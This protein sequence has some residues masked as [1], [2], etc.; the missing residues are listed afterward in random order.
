M[1]SKLSQGKVVNL[2]VNACLMPIC[3]LDGTAVVTVEGIGNT[4]DGM[5]EVQKRL[6][7]SHGS[8]CGF[9][10][11]GIVMSMYTLLRN[12]SK[13]TMKE[14]EHGLDGNLCRCTGYRP[15]LDAFKNFA[16]DTKTNDNHINNNSNNIENHSSNHTNHT[17]DTNTLDGEPKKKKVRLCGGTG[18]PCDCPEPSTEGEEPTKTRPYPLNAEPIFPP[19]LHNHPIHSLM[20][21]NGQTTWYRPTSLDEILYLKE[22]FPHAKIIVGGSEIGIERKFKGSVFP[23]IIAATHVPEL[24]TITWTKEGLEVGLAVSLARLNQEL[25]KRTEEDTSYKSRVFEPYLQQ[26]HWFAGTQIRVFFFFFSK[27]EFFFF[28]L[29]KKSF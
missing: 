2:A 4:R 14:I 11:P 10:T 24:S 1:V 7:D 19:R 5:H 17:P 3:L 22:K 6:S 13:L 15:I 29:K 21:H 28:F 9:C 20:F 18:L 26:L 8:Q 23:V 12:S 27:L 25:K 16:N